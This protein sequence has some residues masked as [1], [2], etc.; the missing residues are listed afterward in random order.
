M[1]DCIFCKIVKKE[2]PAYVIYEDDSTL[3]FL[4]INPINTGHTLVIPKAHIPDFWELDRNIYLHI[5]SI[6]QNISN[7][8][9]KN[10]NPKRVGMLI[11]GWDVPHTHI[12][13]VPLN[14]IDDL[15]SASI[16]NNTLLSPTSI[17]LETTQ[18][19]FTKI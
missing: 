12:H 14:N 17:E 3:A 7:K 11:A 10:L 13:V 19:L 5:Q 6:A 16:I 9:I 2:I 1:N 4:D 8:I 18:N 15:T